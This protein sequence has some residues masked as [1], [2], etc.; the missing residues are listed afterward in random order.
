MVQKIHFVLAQTIQLSNV[1]PL[2][3]VEQGMNPNSQIFGIPHVQFERGQNYFI[4]AASG[5]GKSTFLHILYGLRR[6]YQGTVQ[7]DGTNIQQFSADQWA[8]L[9]QT[10]LNMVFQDLRLFLNFTALDNILLKNQLQNTKTEAEIRQLADELGIEHVLAQPC[11]TLSYGQRQRVALLRALCQPFDFLLLDEPF[12]HLDNA[13]I[14]IVAP[15]LAR[16]CSE[17][18][19]S[20]I[21]VSLGDDY[22]WTFQQHLTL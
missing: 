21:L 13:N 15:L 6:D 4:S 8:N 1:C 20:L 12:S 2:P 9:R 14:R 16:A 18:N 11:E 10:Q 7:I 22:G 19:A 17:N 3:L 5:K